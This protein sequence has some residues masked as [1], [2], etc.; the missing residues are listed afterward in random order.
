MSKAIA[1]ASGSNWSI[2]NGDCVELMRTMPER[3]VHLTVTSIPFAS[4]YTYSASDRDFGNCRTHAE[5][6]DHFRFWVEEL[7]RITMAGRIAAIHCMIL[8][9]SKTRDGVIGLLDFRGDVVRAMQAGGWIFHSETAIW[10][11]PV[12]AM[13]RTKAL[14]LLHKQIKKDSAMSRTGILDYLCAF[15][16]PGTNPEP[17]M[18]TDETYPVT[19]WQQTAS[20]VWM[21]V[22]PSDTLQGRSAREHDDERHIAP[23]QLQVIDRCIDLWSNP[24]DVVFDPFGGIGSTGVCALKLDRRAVLCE[25]KR[26]YYEQAVANLKI[27]ENDKAAPTLFAAGVA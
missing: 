21:D 12:T 22:N 23:L 10:K 9:S 7:G 26:S 15:R 6:F 1:Q 18:H 4:L 8:P 3:S 11:D 17:V 20:P 19:K 5:F 24:G 13:Q 14:G 16:R 2:A 27:A 25:L